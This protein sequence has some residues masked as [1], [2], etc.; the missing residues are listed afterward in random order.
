MSTTPHEEPGTLASAL[1][2][3]TASIQAWDPDRNPHVGPL[4]DALR[5]LQLR[6]DPRRDRLAASLCVTSM[7]LLEEV[8]RQ[9]RIGPE[10]AVSVVG[11]LSLGLKETLSTASA[12]PAVRPGSRHA[13][14]TLKSAEPKSGGL[15]LSLAVDSVKQQK[16]GELMV[17]MNMLTQEQVDRVLEVQAKSQPRKRFGEVAMELGYASEWTVENAL[18]LQARGRGE[19]PTGPSAQAG[20]PWGSS[21]L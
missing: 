19:L 17:R 16:L 4:L 15:S 5:E 6:F 11:E 14:V 21:P 12:A 1:D 10:A 18:R 8:E 3:L 2:G 7:R 9:G 20:D 13:M